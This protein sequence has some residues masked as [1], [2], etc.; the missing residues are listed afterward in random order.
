VRMEAGRIGGW[1]SGTAAQG[2][3]PLVGTA[4]RRGKPARTKTSYMERAV[5]K[6]HRLPLVG[7]PELKPAAANGTK[8]R[9]TARGLLM[10]AANVRERPT[11][12][13]RKG[14]LF[15][16]RGSVL[17]VG[18]REQATVHRNCETALEQYYSTRASRC[19]P[20]DML[21][22]GSRCGNT[23][24]AKCPGMGVA[25]RS[26]RAGTLRSSATNRRAAVD[27]A[28]AS[29]QEFAQ[30]RTA[31]GDGRLLDAAHPVRRCDS[32]GRGSGP[33]GRDLPDFFCPRPFSVIL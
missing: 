2:A 27:A 26:G 10:E 30:V 31:E 9:L 5:A 17:A 14:P 32:G 20:L 15:D 1:Q 23:I 7:E 33:K 13:F 16:I 21:L 8:Y 18:K 6:G 19:P 29:G 3:L 12:A 4:R 25:P 11:D 22:A 28:F 24:L